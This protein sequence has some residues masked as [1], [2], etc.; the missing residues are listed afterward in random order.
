MLHEDLSTFTTS[1][2]YYYYEMF[3]YKICIENQFFLVNRAF[4]V[5]M[6]KNRVEQAGRRR[7]YGARI[8][9]T[10]LGH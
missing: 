8:L 9:K 1:P 5:I 7:Q 2:N 4:Y 10:H 3:S 6:W